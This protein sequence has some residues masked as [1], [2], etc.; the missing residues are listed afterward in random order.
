[1]RFLMTALALQMIALVAVIADKEY[2]LA[3]GATVRLRLAPRDPRSLLQ[4]DY[5]ILA[6]PKL[7]RLNAPDGRVQVVLAPEGEGFHELDRIYQGEE[8]KE[9]E[10]LLTGRVRY[11][12]A[13]FGIGQYFVPA[14]TGRE[15]ERKAR[16]ARVTISGRG[17]AIVVGVEEGER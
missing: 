9:G 17:D 4:G 7:S 14:G 13:D 3:T 16:V 1:M 2:T 6:Y 15:L 12:E 10:V 5:I 11:G 8:L